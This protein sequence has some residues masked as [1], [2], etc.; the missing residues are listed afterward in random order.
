MDTPEDIASL[1][2]EE[3]L[4]LVAEQQ[5]QITQ[6]QGQLAKATATIES[7]QVEVERLTREKKRQATPFSK[8]T[9]V[10]KPKRPG[11]QPGE[12]TFSFRQAPRPEEIT[13]PP[14]N[15]GTG[16]HTLGARLSPHHCRAKKDY[17]WS[18]GG[19]AAGSPAGRSSGLA[20]GL[21]SGWPA[22]GL[23]RYRNS[24]ASAERIIVS[25]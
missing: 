7:L 5:Q 24:G 3:L 14:M 11:R 13:G 16:I 21:T 1:S 10:S 22:P 2:W 12:G 9:R 8:G 6:L 4:A 18:G 20:M 19:S 15:V 17:F 23:A 25:C